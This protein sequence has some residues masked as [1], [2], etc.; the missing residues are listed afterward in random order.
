MAVTRL[1][2][3]HAPA[4]FRAPSFQYILHSGQDEI[5]KS[6][7]LSC[8]HAKVPLL[9]LLVVTA[10]FFASGGAEPLGIQVYGTID[11][12]DDGTFFDIAA[13]GLLPFYWIFSTSGL[14]KVRENPEFSSKVLI[15][16]V[17]TFFPLSDSSKLALRF[18]PLR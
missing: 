12:D 14:F 8:L 5:G 7:M 10:A 11:V 17:L 16:S 3:T 15:F 2:R 9:A 18:L 1:G 4:R 6:I 13:D